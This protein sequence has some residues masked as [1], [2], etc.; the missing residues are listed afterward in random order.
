MDYQN[1]SGN[2]GKEPR[3]SRIANLISISNSNIATAFQVISTA[4]KIIKKLV[5]QLGFYAA[6]LNRSLDHRTGR[7]HLLDSGTMGLSICV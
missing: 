4:Y 2:D 6:Y 5:P 7:A 3:L 1:K